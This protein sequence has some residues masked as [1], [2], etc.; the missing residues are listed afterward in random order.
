[1]IGVLP[2]PPQ[3]DV[4]YLLAIGVLLAVLSWRELRA[5]QFTS[6]LAGLASKVAA[7]DRLSCID[8]L[9]GLPNS[10]VLREALPRAVADCRERGVPLV[11]AFMD[12]DDFGRVNKSQGHDVADAMI[13]M[14]AR[15]SQWVLEQG[16]CTDRIYRRYR[17][18]EFLF[19]LPGATPH[20]AEHILKNV[21]EALNRVHIRASVGAICV[22]PN[23]TVEP[24]EL[25]NL[26]DKGM[27]AVKRAGGNDVQIYTVG[28]EVMP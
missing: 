21:I 11:V 12:L 1:M 22:P 20:K 13:C 18:D 10:R 16:R 28:S 14:T 19:V 9:T 23:H 27:R 24:R 7:L 25:V 17:G 26:S 6:Q 2:H 15:Q 8:E 3:H 5:S 4:P